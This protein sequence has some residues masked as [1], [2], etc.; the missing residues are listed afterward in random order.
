MGAKYPDLP[1]L[2]C[3]QAASQYDCMIMIST[4]LA[5]IMQLET[6]LSYTAGEYYNMM[7]LVAEKYQLGLLYKYSMLVSILLFKL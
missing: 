5:D 2:K 1:Q 3:V 4:G 7:P 6:G